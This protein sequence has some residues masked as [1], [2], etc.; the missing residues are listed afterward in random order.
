MIRLW[1]FESV[2]KGNGRIRGA[3]IHCLN[4]LRWKRDV[5]GTDGRCEQRGKKKYRPEQRA[6]S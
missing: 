6:F 2:R 1:P 5:T 3:G 4:G